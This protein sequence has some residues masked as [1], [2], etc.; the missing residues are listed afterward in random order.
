MSPDPTHELNFVDP[1]DKL[2]RGRYGSVRLESPL[3]AGAQMAL[4]QAEPC[5][6]EQA[7]KDQF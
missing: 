6:L 4:Q 7:G 3:S 2:F 5:F 1:K